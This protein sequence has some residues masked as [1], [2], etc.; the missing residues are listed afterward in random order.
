M[1]HSLLLLFLLVGIAKAAT[2]QQPG[3]TTCPAPVYLFSDN[4]TADQARLHWFDSYY[5][6]PHDLQ[7]RAQGSTDWTL[8]SSLFGNEGGYL[9]LDLTANVTYE[10]RVRVTCAPG[11]VSDWS[12]T[13]TF[14]TSCNPPVALAANDVSSNRVALQWGGVTNASRYELDYR[15]LG[16]TDWKRENTNNPAYSSAVL[17]DLPNQTTYEWRVRAV[18]NERHR[19]DFTNGP[20]FTT[21]CQPPQQ[22]TNEIVRTDLVRV[23]WTSNEPGTRYDLRYRQVNTADWTDVN[24]LST[25]LYTFP[26][27]PHFGHY[28]WQV[29][30]RCPDGSKTAYVVGPTISVVCPLLY[31]LLANFITPT[32]ARISWSTMQEF[33]G[34]FELEWWEQ[35]SNDHTTIRGLTEPSYPL[36]N[37]SPNKTYQVRVLA[38]CAPGAAGTPTL[39]LTFATSC[40]APNI[41][42]LA[43]GT[44]WIGVH[45]NN[46]DLTTLHDLQWRA[47]GS[48][49]W[50]TV[51]NLANGV[52]TL[53]GLTT[54]QTYEVRVRRQC[55][56][57][58]YTDYSATRTAT[59]GCYVP[60]SANAQAGGTTAELQWAEGGTGLYE[61][62][63]R[64]TGGGSYSTVTGL[65]RGGYSLQ[66][67]QP[68]TTYEF[69]VGAICA[70]NTSPTNYLTRTFS[71]SCP[72]P[73]LLSVTGGSLNGSINLYWSGPSN[74]TYRIDRQ[75][76]GE[77]G[78]DVVATQAQLSATFTDIAFNKTYQFR[79]TTVCPSAGESAPVVSN[80]VTLTCPVPFSGF[81]VRQTPTSA[82]LKANT[83]VNLNS[84][85]AGYEV[86]WRSTFGE[87]GEWQ[88]LSATIDGLVYI[89]DLQ[90]NVPYE[91]QLR[92]LCGS[93]GASAYT[94]S[95]LFSNRCQA[96]TGQF[97]YPGTI[98][99]GSVVL[100]WSRGTTNGLFEVQY[101]PQG[102]L[103]WATVSTT[104]PGSYTLTNLSMNRAYEWRVRGLCADGQWSAYS[105]PFVVS[106]QGYSMGARYISYGASEQRSQTS[107]RLS[108]YGQGDI[109]QAE[110]RYRIAR[111]TD[112]GTP[113]AVNSQSLILSTLTPNANYEWQVRWVDG[114]SGE[115][116]P[117]VP[118]YFFQTTCPSLSMTNLS[119]PVGPNSVTL[120]YLENPAWA[121]PF[122]G[123][124]R[125][126]T[127]IGDWQTTIFN[128]QTVVLTGLLPIATYEYRVERICASGDRSVGTT[129]TFQ[130]G[131]C[132]TG[133]NVSL[134]S[135]TT[136]RFMATNV[137]NLP[138]SIQVRPL[139]STSWPVPIAV[140]TSPFDLPGLQPGTAYE[141]RSLKS[142]DPPGTTNF[143]STQLFTTKCPPAPQPGIAA[144]TANSV[145]VNWPADRGALT[146]QWQIF[147]Q[148]AWQSVPGATPPYVLTGLQ[149]NQAYYIRLRNE[150]NDGLI[151]SGIGGQ[152]YYFSAC[153]SG[154]YVGGNGFT[155]TP[156]AVTL[157]GTSEQ[158]IWSG[159]LPDVSFT[160]RWR[161]FGQTAWSE[162]PIATT[163]YV[164]AGLT[165]NTS[166][167]WQI[168]SNCGTETSSS[169]PSNFTTLPDRSSFY[170]V[171]PGDWTDA[172]IWSAATLPTL[173]DPAQVRHPVTVQPYFPAQTQRVQFDTGGGVKFKGNGRMAM[174]Q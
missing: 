105:A 60:T 39:P 151:D 49:D 84:N 26:S 119:Y 101:R 22:L 168:R 146:V 140:T 57:D 132:G 144:R 9:L 43:L 80:T 110:V 112:W 67:L 93:Y 131:G 166:Y 6:L 17:T 153:P 69:R 118:G 46:P 37:L 1:K 79:V 99:S 149:A 11:Q 52:H 89:T 66:N 113:T 86:R 125:Y 44:T 18:C 35:G 74:V 34:T 109:G 24:D 87:P 128:S 30:L 45:W 174:G 7:W 173:N 170:T 155:N 129:S 91:Y 102:E 2:L 29:R 73:Q 126:R 165:G 63:W 142:C 55:A 10:W 81:V 88:S 163:P 8:V 108:W 54:G 157:T 100:Q 122:A 27:L 127:G 61:L 23:S 38:L 116:G 21:T 31:N 169:Y 115:R 58:T 154:S 47:Q 48:P 13:Q 103:T 130:T 3:S 162:T 136:T 20:N 135:A 64:P 139:G 16:E 171:L 104:Q 147:G 50:N 145:S 71:T 95:S 107:V 164:L 76:I 152:V 14:R 40:P 98:V 77:T 59:L 65:G 117:W 124:V 5:N 70:P 94:P 4:V 75:T 138:A 160:L 123:H 28:E 159:G 92:T 158:I 120:T 90:P 96:P 133:F 51:A 137:N 97:Q 15:R 25:S 32:S 56:P 172:S 78:W 41:T 42:F 121:E 134:L 62:Q 12:A 85:S 72:A 106:P 148:T 68:N 150:C 36:Q 161:A 141:W 156:T 33:Q 82:W 19:S 143:A 83:P 111:T 167:E 114:A 53:E